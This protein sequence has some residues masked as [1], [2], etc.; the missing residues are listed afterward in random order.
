[1]SW[2]IT[3][4]PL[5]GKHL[6]VRGNFRS[7]HLDQRRLKQHHVS[8]CCQNFPISLPHLPCSYMAQGMKIGEETERKFAE[9]D[10]SAL[11]VGPLGL[12]RGEGNTEQAE[13]KVQLT[14]PGIVKPRVIE[15]VW[16]GC[17]VMQ[18][19]KDAVGVGDNSPWRRMSHIT[20]L[21]AMVSIFV[22]QILHDEILIP[23]LMVSIGGAFVR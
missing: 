4:I 18:E 15:C 14:W 7:V 19:I 8:Q 1:M 6:S 13:Y 12:S 16:N 20:F 23:M 10:T 3:R 2:K 11:L 21:S 22:S 9:M 5:K 17:K